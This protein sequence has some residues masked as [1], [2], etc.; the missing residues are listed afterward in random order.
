MRHMRNKLTCM[1][2]AELGPR[3]EDCPS[4]DARTFN[5]G[6]DTVGLSM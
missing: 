1:I 4:E 5:D 3:E 6:T 2:C